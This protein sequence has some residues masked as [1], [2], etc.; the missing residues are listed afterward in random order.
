M[1]QASDPRFAGLTRRPI[2]EGLKYRDFLVVALMLDDEDLFP[3]NWIYIHSKDVKVGRIQNFNNWSRDMIPEAG[4]TCVGLEY[5]CFEGDG[6]SGPSGPSGPKTSSA[7][8]P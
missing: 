5:F 6:L 4:K 2:G 8:P 1:I 7:N 3:D